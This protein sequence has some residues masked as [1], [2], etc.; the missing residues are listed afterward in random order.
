MRQRLP[1]IMQAE[2]SECGVV[3]L[4]MIAGFYGR[5][6][7]LSS[8]R[9]ECSTSLRGLTLEHLITA[10]QRLHLASRPLRVELSELQE[11][12]LPCILHWEMS[13]FVVLR[14]VSRSHLTIHDPAIGVRRISLENADQSFTGV[15]LELWPTEDF[16]RKS[17]S[18]PVTI[19]ELLG[20]VSGVRRLGAKTLFLS[21]LTELLVICTPLLLQFTVDRATA[22]Q[23]NILY[24][25]VVALTVCCLL[26]ALATLSRDLSI[27]NLGN[28]ISLAWQSNLLSHLLQLSLPFFEKRSTGDLLS[29]FDAAESVR[30]MLVGSYANILV[31]GL[32]TAFTL[33][34]MFFYSPVLASIV[35]A[36]A[37]VFLGI[38]QG[39]LRKIREASASQNMHEVALRSHLLET[40]QGIR[41]IK[42]FKKTGWRNSHWLNV[43]VDL[44]NARSTT[45]TTRS[46]INGSNTA[47][48]GV[49]LALV[50]GIGGHLLLLHKFSVG[51]FL[52]FLVYRDHFNV[53]AFALINGT[54]DLSAMSTQLSRVGDIVR[55]SPDSAAA[56][57]LEAESM[58]PSPYSMEINDVSF[59]YSDHD[60]WIIQNLCLRIQQGECVSITGR[61]GIGKST[62]VKL[63]CGLLRPNEGEIYANGKP[64]NEEHSLGVVLQEDMVFAGTIAENIHFFA[65]TPDGSLIEHCARLAALAEDIDAMPMRYQT[66]VGTG[67]AGLSGGQ[68]QRLLI[69]RALY[70]KPSIL[71]FDESTSHLD[72]LTERTISQSLSALSITRILIA[73]R[74]ETIAIA[75]RVVAFRDR[76]LIDIT[77]KFRALPPKTSGQ[78]ARDYTQRSS[79]HYVY[80]NEQW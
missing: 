76:K 52:A 55:E 35:I 54:Y 56:A 29:R 64:L 45:E 32:V 4:A 27:I 46:W 66:Q 20:S 31:S 39:T 22:G 18:V 60:P 1:L 49:E 3:C 69:A 47:I 51:A 10:A 74:P 21:A 73:H 67:G 38:R 68:K 14:S 17:D 44:M 53:R 59:R 16:T 11:V 12:S 80:S 34:A 26:E 71:I 75:D 58:P 43:L 28:R 13:H 78:T 65:E 15:V 37:I 7:T 2:T 33:V 63:M 24:M 36:G 19:T 79:T 8:L 57:K 9:R 5:A 50:I 41:P 61:S 48:L 72:L 42:L 62:L 6:T 23:G 25:G 40:L 77:D 30:L 70:T